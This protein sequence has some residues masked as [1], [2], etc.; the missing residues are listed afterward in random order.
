VVY[1]EPTAA[2]EVLPIWTATASM[3]VLEATMERIQQ[4]R[5]LGLAAHHMVNLFVRHN[6]APLQ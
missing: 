5:G 1:A 6:I 3:A 4:L 2:P